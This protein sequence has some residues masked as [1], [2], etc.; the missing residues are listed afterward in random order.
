MMNPA[1]LKT[2]SEL[3]EDYLSE[4]LLRPATNKLYRDIAR[5]FT[6]N[7][8]LYQ[9]EE[10]NAAEV[11]KWRTGV[12]SRAKEESWNMYRRH[13]R[14]LWNHAMRHHGCT[15]NPFA[16][17]APAR[18]PKL[19]KKTVD[20]ADLQTVL[21]ALRDTGDEGP[22][23]RPTW[24]WSIVINTFYYSGIRRLQLVGLTWKDIDF[25][26]ATIHLRATSSK[27]HREWFIPIAQPLQPE[28]ENLYLLTTERL[29]RT[30]RSEEQV[31]NV[32][33]FNDGF[34]GKTMTVDQLGATFW[35]LS[36]ATNIRIS[37]HRLRH[38]MATELAASKDI[39]TLQELLGHT[40]ISTTMQYVHP[41]MG[42]MRNL[43]ETFSS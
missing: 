32:T 33:L 21:R 29:G 30:P 1:R 26:A 8:G 23:V 6:E 43:L 19:R 27:T 36:K 41:D 18:A 38:T 34:K 35:R 42:R 20:S 24:F 16:D 22:Y 40:N 12:L 5:R 39:R 2:I 11:R 4:R 13:M 37:P 7:T 15:S 9:I 25:D 17:T 31:F 28:L 10:I 14:A 3:V